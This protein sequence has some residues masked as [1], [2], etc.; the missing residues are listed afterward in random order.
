MCVRL[1]AGQCL[2]GVQE[3]L[4][5]EFARILL[6]A[7]HT[8]QKTVDAVLV[9]G[10]QFGERRDLAALGAGDAVAFFKVAQGAHCLFQRRA[11]AKVP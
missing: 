7:R 9:A 5:G 4:L 1:P 3:S 11:A 8:E 2:V 10:H 6:R